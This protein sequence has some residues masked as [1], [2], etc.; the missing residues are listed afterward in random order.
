M[1]LPQTPDV[2]YSVQTSRNDDFV[3][4]ICPISSKCVFFRLAS[5]SAS[6]TNINWWF[7]ESCRKN[8]QNNSWVAGEKNIL[9]ISL[10]QKENSNNE[11][12][13]VLGSNHLIWSYRVIRIQ[14]KKTHPA[15]QWIWTIRGD[16][17][18]VTTVTTRR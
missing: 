7:C 10:A 5:V 9:K 18:L 12:T 17:A 14:F 6:L 1:M 16:W 11:I 8:N 4:N 13:V 2:H 15:I 3:A